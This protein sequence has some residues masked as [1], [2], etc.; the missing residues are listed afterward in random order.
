LFIRLISGDEKAVVS[1]LPVIQ[2]VVIG[3]H[4]TG[5]KDSKSYAAELFESVRDFLARLHHNVRVDSVD[6]LH[7]AAGIPKCPECG[8]SPGVKLLVLTGASDP[9]R[10]RRIRWWRDGRDR[11]VLPVFKAGLKPE[12]LLPKKFTLY[13][14]VFW[15]RAVTEAT[16]TVLSSAG[17]TSDAHRIFISYRRLETE[18]LAEDL[19]DA[20]NREGFDVFLDRYSVP[21]AASFQLRLHQE[22]AEK[23]MV[24]LLESDRFGESR[25]T[26]EEIAIC[27]KSRI[28]LFSLLLPHGVDEKIATRL[29]DVKEEHRLVLKKAQFKSESKVIKLPNNER[30]R[31]WGALKEAARRDVVQ[32]IKRRHDRALLLRRNT[33]REQMAE[34]LRKAK[35]TPVKLRADGL[36]SVRGKD[37]RNYVIWVTTRPPEVPDFQ[38]THSGSRDPRGTVGVVVGHNQLLE[39]ESLE[40]QAWLAGV[41]KLVVVDEGLLVQAAYDIAEGTLVRR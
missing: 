22:L 27:K 33:I 3:F 6:C 10:I 4:P 15:Q 37:K 11:K 31:Q 12:R 36:M 35:A 38:V 13:N 26:S 1:G 7:D 40:R 32:E 14:A 29:P 5:S 21:A 16:T 34:A 39:K 41:S 28:G 8:D 23:G 2:P 18:P 30:F 9:Y 19:F 24:L 25:W 17:F 20:L